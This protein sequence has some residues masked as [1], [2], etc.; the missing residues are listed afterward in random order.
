MNHLLPRFLFALVIWLHALSGYGGPPDKSPKSKP[1]L[2]ANYYTWYATGAG[3]HKIWTHW[4]RHPVA[5]KMN[6]EAKQTG[7]VVQQ[8]GRKDIASVLWPLAGLYD[9]D[10]R[11]IV[12]WHIRLSKAAGIDALLVDWWGP[13]GWE[14]VPGLT[15]FTFEDVVLPIAAEEGFKVALFDEPVQF[16]PAATSREWIVK[17]LKKYKDH[18]AYLKIDGKPVYYLY[19][20]SFAPSLTPAKFEELRAYVEERVGPVYWIVDAISNSND[21][22]RIPDPWRPVAGIGSF[23][24]YGT[25]SIFRES[26]YK[27]LAERYAVVVRQAHAAGKM[28]CVPVH[29]GH[30]NLQEGNTNHFEMP[31]QDGETFRGYLKAAA[32]AGADY[33][34]VTSFN[35]WPES[36]AIEPSSSWRDPYQ[37]LKILANWQGVIFKAPPEPKRV[38]AAR[39]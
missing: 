19:Q 34:M 5:D 30:D 13:G 37:Y 2:F 15:Q 32:D 33:V 12:R 38:K 25:F 23:S 1:L 27:Q 11:E 4:V 20:V 7:V 18:P 8:L 28:M 26:A 31:R 10:D 29:P 21:N 6:L 24:F 22:F 3:P 17:Y 36:T 16:L 14:R 35:E 39:Q 9:S